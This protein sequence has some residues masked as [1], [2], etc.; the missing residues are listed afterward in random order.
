MAERL[1]NHMAEATES[2]AKTNP[3]EEY[4][5]AYWKGNIQTE[6]ISNTASKVR[7]KIAPFR[8]KLAA[9]QIAKELQLSPGN[10]VLELG[11]GLGLLGKEIRDEIDGEVNY[12]GIELAYQS[13]KVSG[14]QGILES[15]ANVL[16]LPFADN[17]FDALVTTDVLEHIK[18]NDRVTSE[19]L[20]VLK[21]G[22]KAFVVIADPSE[23]RFKEIHD[24]IDRTNY[25][26]D[27]KYWEDLFNKKGLKV[28]SKN[29]EKYRK[30]DWRKIFNLPFLVKLKNKPGFACAFN[31]VNRP[32]TYIIEKP[33]DSSK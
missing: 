9:R 5:Y 29:S 19:M 3:L 21:P 32:G 22:G 8:F 14:E 20:R 31:P 2:F 12:F 15:Q 23:A 33:V 18:D 11:S 6:T 24:H 26:S 16:D 4:K 17:T 10:K 1:P 30:R 28:L 25:R 7:E 13:A 27:V